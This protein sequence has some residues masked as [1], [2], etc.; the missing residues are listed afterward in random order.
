M[1][2]LALA[3]SYKESDA[4]VRNISQSLTYNVAEKQLA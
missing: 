2:V 3:L 4:R 1:S